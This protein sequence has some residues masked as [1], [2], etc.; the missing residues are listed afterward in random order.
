MDMKK[1]FTILFFA[2]ISYTAKADQL[3]WISYEQAKEAAEFLQT[4]ETVVLW[5]ACCDDD[6]PYDVIVESVTYESVGDGY[7]QVVLTGL[8]L[9][10]ES[11][12]LELDLAYV[13]FLLGDGYAY[14]VGSFL[15]Y[16]CDPCVEP[17]EW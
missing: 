7:Y 13:H 10:G 2:L 16:E 17:F 12:T 15:G 11:V 3:A 5:C 9:D 8:T 14:C 4:Q 6:L 1:L